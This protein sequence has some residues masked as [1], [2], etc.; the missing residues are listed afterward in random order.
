MKRLRHE[1]VSL[2][3]CWPATSWSKSTPHPPKPQ[4]SCKMF[5]VF[6]RTRIVGSMVSG[7][8]R[9]D[10]DSERRVYKDIPIIRKENT[11]SHRV[12]EMPSIFKAIQ[13]FI[14]DGVLH[15]GSLS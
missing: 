7:R 2:C 5:C 15:L 6:F 8:K 12:F 4:T 14:F 9:L 1:S 3:S 11:G 10:I 13:Y